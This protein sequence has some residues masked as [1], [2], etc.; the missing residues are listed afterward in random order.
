MEQLLRNGYKAKL[1]PSGHQIS[2]KFSKRNKGS[3]PPNLLQIANTESNSR[4]LRA[5]RQIGLKPNPARYPAG[6]PEFFIKMLTDEGDLV[7]DPFAGSN[8]TGEVCEHLK[9]HWIAVDIVE[10]YLEGSKFRFDKFCV[11]KWVDKKGQ[12]AFL[13][14][15]NTEDP[16]KHNGKKKKSNLNL[17]K[18]D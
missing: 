3:I 2:S 9:R 15:D 1:R 17:K 16:R 12:T 6:L 18:G 7:V 10:E 13:L 14:R 4:Y 5:C 11:G 8:V